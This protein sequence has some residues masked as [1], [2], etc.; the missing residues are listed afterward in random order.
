MSSPR[1]FACDY[2]RLRA[3]LLL[4]V[5]QPLQA[6]GNGLDSYLINPGS[7]G[8]YWSSTPNSGY[9]Y[10]AWNLFFSSGYFDGRD[11]SRYRGQPVRPV[12]DPDE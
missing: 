12:R 8:I 6:A 9:S 2:V 1:L 3:D 7:Y 10:N 11:S 4:A 5:G